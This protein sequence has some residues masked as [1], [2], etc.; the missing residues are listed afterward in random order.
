MPDVWPSRYVPNLLYS[1]AS[2][3]LKNQSISQLKLFLREDGMDA[4]KSLSSGLFVFIG[5]KLS[6]AEWSA[7]EAV[8]GSSSSS[9]SSSK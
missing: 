6:C 1:P 5:S 4:I 7:A 8:V 9:S 2:P 3:I